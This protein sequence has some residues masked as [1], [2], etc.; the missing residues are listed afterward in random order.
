MPAATAA[1]PNRRNVASM[2]PPEASQASGGPGE[3]AI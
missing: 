3:E 1:Q 2:T